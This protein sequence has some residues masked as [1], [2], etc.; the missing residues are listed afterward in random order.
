MHRAVFFDR[1]GVIT[2]EGAKPVR[3][4]ELKICR[5]AISAL[6]L[7]P[8]TFKKIIV[9]NQSWI[10]RGLLTE[11]E[12]NRTH[13]RLY[14]ELKLQDA[15]IDG[16]YFCPHLDLHNC[17]CRKP[18]PGMLLQ[19]QKEHNIDLKNSY[20]IGDMLRDLAAGKEVGCT[21]ILVK[22]R[23]AGKDTGVK[24][25]PD[26]VAD[27]VYEAAKLIL[28]HENEKLPQKEIARSQRD[29]SH[30]AGNKLT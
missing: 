25:E 23:H 9:T 1:D 28:R 3:E 29:I 19:A 18:K 6:K 16:V 22:T 12:L 15:K 2:E 30:P 10:A 24:L 5:K 27:D 7:L 13:Q 11:E 26:F 4:H 17:N 20:V 8:D 21:T 14:R